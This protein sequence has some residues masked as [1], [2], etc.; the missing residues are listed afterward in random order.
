MKG[1][2]HFWAFLSIF[3][4]KK[5]KKRI[6]RINT[7]NKKIPMF[8]GTFRVLRGI[9]GVWF[10]ANKCRITYSWNAYL[11]FFC[12]TATFWISRGGQYLPNPPPGRS[13]NSGRLVELGLKGVM[14]TR[15]F[16]NCLLIPSLIHRHFQISSMYS[17]LNKY[18]VWEHTLIDHL[19]FEVFAWFLIHL[20]CFSFD[21]VSL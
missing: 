8:E 10:F 20:I 3:K 2:W 16:I 6:S 21:R 7:S 4:A 1:R 17:T 11:T 15:Q 13:R 5:R 12:Q 19:F 18:D 14:Q 9:Q